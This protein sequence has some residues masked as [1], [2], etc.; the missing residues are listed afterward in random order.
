MYQCIVL[1]YSTDKPTVAVVAD[2]AV[3]AFVA[4]VADVAV[5]V[6]VFAAADAAADI[7]CR[8]WFPAVKRS[9]TKRVLVIFMCVCVAT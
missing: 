7:K 6:A 3:A 8:R 4:V 5:A 2:V 9:R 1:S